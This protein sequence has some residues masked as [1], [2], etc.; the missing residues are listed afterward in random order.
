MSPNTLAY[1]AETPYT[2]SVI[3]SMRMFALAKPNNNKTG[4][5]RNS[6]AANRAIIPR[7][8]F[9]DQRYVSRN[10]RFQLVEDVFNIIACHLHFTDK[11]L[12]QCKRQ[13]FRKH[14]M[15]GVDLLQNVFLRPACDKA[16]QG[17]AHLGL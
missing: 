2:S 4:K 9:N 17:T 16:H 15:Q 8:R 6:N 11:Y 7:L 10:S 12:F 14:G 1:C 5:A 13:H 3:G